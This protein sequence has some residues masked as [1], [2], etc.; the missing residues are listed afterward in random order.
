MSDPD[1]VRTGVPDGRII[2]LTATPA[3]K[4]GDH[5]VLRG[6]LRLDL[7]DEDVFDKGDEADSTSTQ[8]TLGLNALAYY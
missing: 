5:V 2:T 8:L 4:V 6:D 1:G 3:Y 7:V